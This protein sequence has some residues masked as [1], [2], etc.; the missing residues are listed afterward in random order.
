MRSPASCDEERIE[1]V[2]GEDLFGFD[3]SDDERVT[4]LIE[5]CEL[6][7]QAGIV[8]GLEGNLENGEFAP[9]STRRAAADPPA[10]RRPLTMRLPGRTFADGRLER[11]GDGGVFGG[12]ELLFDGIELFEECGG[13]IRAEERI[14]VR[15]VADEFVE[16][17]AGA[18][19]DGRQREA[20]VAGEDLVQLAQ[21]G[22]G[23]LVGED[24]EG[25][26]A[27][28]EDVADFVAEIAVADGFGGDVDVGG[29]FEPIL[30]VQVTEVRVRW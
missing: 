13:G 22:R 10:P 28:G 3:G 21:V 23:R 18:I 29:F 7:A 27:E 30:D 17:G 16:L 19:E 9:L 15:G 5:D 8:L 11:I 6:V 20:L 25:E 4:E 14:G 26:G 12:G 2:E 24:V 1:A